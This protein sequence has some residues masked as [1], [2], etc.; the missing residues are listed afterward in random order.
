MLLSDKEAKK[1]PLRSIKYVN[2]Y[3]IPVN[4]KFEKTECHE[5]KKTLKSVFRILQR[6]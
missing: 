5:N 2:S 1:N 4:Q 6:K 3:G